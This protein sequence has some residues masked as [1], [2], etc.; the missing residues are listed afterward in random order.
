MSWT[1]EE[2]L[3]LLNKLVIF[4]DG[5]VQKKPDDER[6]GQDPLFPTAPFVFLKDVDAVVEGPCADWVDIRPRIW[7]PDAPFGRYNLNVGGEPKEKVSSLD[8]I[9]EHLGDA[10]TVVVFATCC[11][12]YCTETWKER[13]RNLKPD[14][15]WV[16]PQM[17]D[18]CR[19]WMEPRHTV[20]LVQSLMRDHIIGIQ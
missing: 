9:V 3:N 1:K 6:K 18:L 5:E 16:F 12:T 4:S 19:N 7:D 13:V 11:G 14:I 10:K 2:F 8:T 17:A 15:T 20:E